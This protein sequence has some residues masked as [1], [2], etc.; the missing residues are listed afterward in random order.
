M[1]AAEPA[2]ELRRLHPVYDER[3]VEARF[4]SSVLWPSLLLS[5][6]APAACGRV[7]FDLTGPAAGSGGGEGALGD[8]SAGL[9]TVGLGGGAGSANGGGAGSA[10][11]G[12]ASAGGGSGNGSGGGVSGA[13]GASGV[14]GALSTGGA[15]L[16]GGAGAG[17][18]G[19]GGSDAGANSCPGCPA[20]V[21][22][23]L[24]GTTATTYIGGPGAELFPDLCPDDE[25]VIGYAGY[26]GNDGTGSTYLQRLAAICGKV[27]V[28]AAAPYSIT[29]TESRQLPMRGQGGS[30]AF[31]TTCP[32]DEVIVGFDS[33]SGNYFMELSIL[34]APLAVTSGPGGYALA[35]G[36][37]TPEAAVGGPDGQKQPRTPCPAGQIARG[38]RMHAGLVVNAFSMACATPSLTRAVGAG[39]GTFADCASGV[40]TGGTCRAP[41]CTSTASCSCAL[42]EGRDY[43]LCSAPLAY[44]SAL[45]TCVGSGMRLSRLDTDLEDGWVRATATSRS[46]A[47]YR[48]GGDSLDVAST[49]KWIDGTTFW[50]GDATGSAPPGV[51]ANFRPN[52]EP[53][54][55]TGCVSVG[56]T[57]GWEAH[58][59]TSAKAYVCE[60]Y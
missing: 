2:V 9:S 15:G 35:L 54:I 13:G 32:P 3:L 14:G 1:G 37:A 25:V 44:A 55:A 51:Y 42:F 48:V 46:F 16:D 34:C 28:S 40:C 43:A 58:D 18:G 7:G 53:G 23:G 26:G 31:R 60:R 27:T 10:N 4:R 17:A 6:L 41:S 38:N 11:G 57:Y 33:K 20:P 52:L 12:A 49:W 56:T 39:C 19:S 36:P 22:F 29:I 24:S 50:Q 45:S 47:D 8:G 21:G 59:C 5:A 30:V